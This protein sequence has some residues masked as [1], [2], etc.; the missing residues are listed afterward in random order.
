MF[1]SCN[2]SVAGAGPRSS[3]DC[4]LQDIAR[5]CGRARGWNCMF[6]VMADDP[7]STDHGKRK[8]LAAW[9]K[10]RIFFRKK[11]EFR[12]IQGNTS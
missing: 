3:A 9:K 2:G 4:R 12:F 1:P 11:Q 10:G 5:G 8:G 7:R 6:P